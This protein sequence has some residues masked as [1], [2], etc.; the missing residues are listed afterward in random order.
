[1][2]CSLAK[3]LTTTT[4][5]AASLTV[6]AKTHLLP[7]Q[8]P[9]SSS[10]QSSRRSHSNNSGLQRL[11]MQGH[12]LQSGGV[13]S[14]QH[15]T[16]HCSNSTWQQLLRL[17]PPSAA[18]SC[19]YRRTAATSMMQQCIVMVQSSTTRRRMCARRQLMCL[20]YW[21]AAVGMTTAQQ[22]L[23]ARVSAAAA[24]GSVTQTVV[25]RAWQHAMPALWMC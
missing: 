12:R 1:M 13:Q 8:Q 11:L 19:T 14:W 20:P 21:T 24:T 4:A 22:C 5:A 9:C 10:C 6:Q 7:A 23:Q 3:L 2:S 15:S 16:R 17:L 25:N 18:C